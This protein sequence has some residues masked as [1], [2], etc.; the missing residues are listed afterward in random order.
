MRG[1]CDARLAYYKNIPLHRARANVAFLGVELCFGWWR[2]SVA[3]RLDGTQKPVSDQSTRVAACRQLSPKLQKGNPRPPTDR[4]ARTRDGG[5]RTE[6]RKVTSNTVCTTNIDSCAAKRRS[7][8]AACE[9]S[10][11]SSGQH[12]TF[13]DLPVSVRGRTW[14][15]R[16]R[17]AALHIR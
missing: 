4:H 16:R 11:L 2:G 12:R 13:L 15:A 14:W 6:H 1:N 3:R 17:I 5:I 10:L 9:Q 7:W 8:Q